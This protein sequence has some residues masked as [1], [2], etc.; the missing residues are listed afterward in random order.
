MHR[1]HRFRL[2]APLVGAL[3]LA[4]GAA[5]QGGNQSDIGFPI[6]TGSGAVGGN[7]SGPGLRAGNALFARDSRSTRFRNAT[8][9]CSVRTAAR[10]YRD[11]VAGVPRDPRSAA[12]DALLAGSPSADPAAVA[13]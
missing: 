10:A 11:S 5:A 7:M 12:V 3:L 9:G 8:V 1:S 6:I 4:T 13:A 2:V